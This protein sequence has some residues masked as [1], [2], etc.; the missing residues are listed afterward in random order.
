MIH[1]ISG[2]EFIRKFQHPDLDLTLAIGLDLELKPILKTKGK[3]SFLLSSGTKEGENSSLI[4]SSGS[5]GGA[6]MNLISPP[7]PTQFYP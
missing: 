3:F 1:L 7:Y 5:L 2:T 6:G 4:G